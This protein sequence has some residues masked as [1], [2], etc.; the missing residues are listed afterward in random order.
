MKEKSISL[1]FFGLLL[2]LT[3]CPVAS[4]AEEKVRNED[5]PGFFQQLS[6]RYMLLEDDLDDIPRKPTRY[7]FL[8]EDAEPLRLFSRPAG[9]EF[10]VFNLQWRHGSVFINNLTLVP[11][12]LKKRKWLAPEGKS[13]FFYRLFS[14]QNRLLQEAPM[15]IYPILHFDAAA[16]SDGGLVGG[17]LTRS[18]FDFVLKIPLPEQSARRILFYRDLRG[19]ETRRRTTAE[20]GDTEQTVQIGGTEF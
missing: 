13:R 2:C 19:L 3:A 16:G 7:D 11:G 9:P 4:I 15:D 14:N 10:A 8:K 17:A 5:D 12:A 1:F 20:S 6:G 18:E